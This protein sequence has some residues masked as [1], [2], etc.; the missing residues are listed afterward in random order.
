MTG[1][2]IDARLAELRPHPQN[3]N[4]HSEA[5][6]GRLMQSL[7]TFGQ[8]KPIVIW[9][10][11]IIAGH[12]LVEA[13]RGLGWERLQASDMSEEWTEAQ[14]T[15]FVGA[16][17][18]L[19]RLADP[20]EAALAAL[21]ASLADVDRELAALAAGSEER[22]R[23]L[24]ATL[25]QPAGD[26]PG[27]QVDKA[28][29]LQAKWGTATGQLWQLGEHRLICGDCTD[30]AVVARVMGG[31][32][33]VLL[34][35][36]P[37]YAQQRDYKKRIDNWDRLMQGCFQSVQMEENGQVLVNL[38][39][40]HVDGEWVPYW[41]NWIEWMRSVG[42]KRFG[43]Y[44]WD[45]TFALPGDWNGRLA[46][47]HEFIFHFCKQKKRPRKVVR[48]KWA[49]KVIHEGDATGLR[50]ADGS[51]SG[52]THAGKAT[53]KWRIPESVARVEPP[54]FW[55]GAEAE[56]EVEWFDIPQSVARVSPAMGGVDGHPA[57]FS[58][59][60]ASW[61]VDPWSEI[62]E[63][64]YEPFSGSGTTLIAC[65]RLGRRCRAVEIEPGYVAVALERWA[66]MTGKTPVLVGG[67]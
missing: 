60:L 10:G 45:K 35:T 5:Q 36:S 33:A 16:D 24:L 23:E 52:W 17:N 59:A 30:A 3:Y 31:E 57:P 64:V 20:D 46:P 34:F 13:A 58:V 12:G 18:E 19:A 55:H 63:I 8:P 2:Q 56:T 43:F 38:G 28:A 39:I 61:A 7:E 22:L 49:G 14:A 29:E 42:W 27:A 53:Q 32:K 9:R 25:E 15:A 54:E 6:I 50:A 65:E 1:R 62:G 67:Q 47:A 44:V 26:D 21:A 40:V 11:L 41:D 4:R 37:P 51:M 66:T 48:S